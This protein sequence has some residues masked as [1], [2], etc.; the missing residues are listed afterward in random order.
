MKENNLLCSK[1]VVVDFVERARRIVKM[2]L[3]NA[4]RKPQMAKMAAHVQVSCT[5]WL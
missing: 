2:V 5:N 3:W 1:V 4:G